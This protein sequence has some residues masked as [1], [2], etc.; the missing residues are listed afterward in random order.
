[1][2]NITYYISKLLQNITT[3]TNSQNLQTSIN[4]EINNLNNQLNIINM[5]TSTV[6]DRKQYLQKTINDNEASYQ[7]SKSELREFEQQL[8]QKTKQYILLM[9]ETDKIKN[10]D[11]ILNIIKI[12]SEKHHNLITCNNNNNNIF[13]KY[14]ELNKN[15]ENNIVKCEISK[16]SI[17]P[18]LEQLKSLLDEIN[19]VEQQ[20]EN[21]NKV[22]LNIST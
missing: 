1:M 7:L 20:I 10:S 3:L 18:V 2:D 16:E 22:Q 17:E 15:M 21:L 9:N 14:D 6:T 11:N 19:K 12:L 13:D 5:N 4:S 8:H